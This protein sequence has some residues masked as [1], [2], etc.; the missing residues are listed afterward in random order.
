MVEGLR[1]VLTKGVSCTS[2]GDAPTTS[3]IR[4][5]PQEI[6]H[7]SLQN[8][9]GQKHILHSLYLISTKYL[10]PSYSSIIN[11]QFGDTK[12]TKGKKKRAAHSTIWH[13]GKKI[14]LKIYKPGHLKLQNVRSTLNFS[15][16]DDRTAVSHGWPK[17]GSMF[18]YNT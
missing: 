8:A 15:S 18:Y 3:V 16:Q 13:T 4:I 17:Y 12:K 11:I 1:D 2:R 5:R 6:T 9:P 10:K 7:W 14:E